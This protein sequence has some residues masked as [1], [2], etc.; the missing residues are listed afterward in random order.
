MARHSGKNGICKL[1]S[2]A[3]VALEGWDFEETVDTIDLTAATDSWRDVDSTFKS[4]KGSV[5]MRADHGA[6]GQTVRAG[7]QVAVEFYSEGDASGKTYW[8]GTA[9]VTGHGI[10][11]PH[12]GAVSRSYT[13]EGKGA[14]STAT[15]V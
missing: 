3:V 11:S 13:L 15:V 5:K 14:L 10:D 12:D 1:A 2:N 9:I 6:L 4:W 7:D 8:S